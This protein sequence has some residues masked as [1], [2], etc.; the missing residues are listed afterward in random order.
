MRFRLFFAMLALSSGL[1]EVAHASGPVERLSQVLLHPT[2]K[3]IVVVRWSTASEGFLFSRD[4]GKTFAALCSA[5]ITS[6]GGI[7][8][9][10]SDTVTK[11]TQAEVNTNAA[12]LLDSAGQL[13]ATQLGGMWSDDGTG[14]SWSKSLTEGWPTSLALDPKS[15]ELLAV[16]NVSSNVGG[17]YESRALLMRR[18][19]SGAWTSVA[20]AGELVA[21]KAGQQAY[22]G[23]LKVTLTD[24][25][26][27]IYASVRVSQGMDPQQL[28]HIVKSDDGG[29]T[30]SMG[31]ALAAEQADRFTLVAVDPGNPKRLLGALIDDLA[32]DVLLLSED[33][34]ATFKEYGQ[35]RYLTGAAF[36]PDGAVYL[37]D[38]GDAMDPGGLWTA[39]ALGQPLTHIAGTQGLDCV[40]WSQANNNF[41]VCQGDRVRTFDPASETVADGNVVRISEVPKLLECPNADVGAICQDQL[42]QGPAWCC[43][44]HYP[45]TA[46]CDNYDVTMRGSQRVFCGKSGLAYDQ[47]VGRTCDQQG[48]GQPEGGVPL[49]D[50]GNVPRDAGTLDA[51]A[52]DAGRNDAGKVTDEPSSKSDDGCAIGDKRADGAWTSL[53]ML[54]MVLGRNLRRRKK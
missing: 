35:L 30:W 15:G 1:G 40:T 19:A 39:P 4:G 50:A 53:G 45:C 6:L 22:G 18:G 8:D 13:H 2:D 11:L 49:L 9:A 23:E 14:C 42:N 16:L 33:E 7:V 25:G 43:T 29:K 36:A 34:G 38:Q 54:L 37:S 21:H 51:G 27:R 5:G 47:M 31:P 10:G 24:T 26:T 48:M 3:N 52:R 12:T 32:A 20:E 41:Y 44:G 28:M 17:T 46:F